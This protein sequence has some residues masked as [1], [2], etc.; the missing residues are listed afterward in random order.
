MSDRVA[1]LR[2]VVAE[3]AETIR[4]LRAAALGDQDDLAACPIFS[5]TE[6]K[7]VGALLAHGRVSMETIRCAVYGENMDNASDGTIRQTILKIRRKMVARGLVRPVP[8]VWGFGYA[9]SPEH[10]AVVRTWIAGR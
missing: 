7:I 4:Q 3:Q 10:A 2:A 1:K 5:A 9:I 6:R 8:I